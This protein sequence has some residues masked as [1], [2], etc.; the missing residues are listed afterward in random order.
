MF[1]RCGVAPPHPTA[2]PSWGWL[3]V[4]GSKPP[5]K[6]PEL[7]TSRKKAIPGF[8]AYHRGCSSP[9]ALGPKSICSRS[10]TAGQKRKM[11]TGGAGACSKFAIFEP[12]WPQQPRARPRRPLRR[13]KRPRRARLTLAKVDEEK[14]SDGKGADGTADGGGATAAGAGPAAA[15]PE[16]AKLMSQPTQEAAA[17]AGVIVQPTVPTAVSPYRLP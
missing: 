1:F 4:G 3:R 9:S 13:R 11:S 7:V 10:E 17:I 12:L 14:G 2:K 6:M 5:L 15:E 8:M 16:K